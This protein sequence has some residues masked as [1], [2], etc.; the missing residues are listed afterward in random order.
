MHTAQLHHM[1]VWLA[2]YVLSHQSTCALRRLTARQ[3]AGF[4][5]W[6]LLDICQIL[7][8]ICCNSGLNL[9]PCDPRPLPSGQ[10]HHEFNVRRQCNIIPLVI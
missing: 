6:P 9:G 7:A 2:V 5:V 8:N 3:S 4:F 10:L 1:L